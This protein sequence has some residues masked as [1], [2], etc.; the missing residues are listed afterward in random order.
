[1]PIIDIDN[2]GG[3]DISKIPKETDGIIVTNIFG[4]IVDIEKYITYCNKNNIILLF[5]NAATPYTFYKG[6]N[7]VNYGTGSIISFHHTKP[8]VIW[9]VSKIVLIKSLLPV[10]PFTNTYL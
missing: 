2:D 10:F 6:K 3:L 5:D 7:C 8:C 9:C 4:N 1:M